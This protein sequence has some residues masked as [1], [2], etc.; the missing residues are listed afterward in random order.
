VTAVIAGPARLRTDTGDAPAI[1][2][3]DQRAPGDHLLIVDASTLAEGGFTTTDADRLAAVV[4]RWTSTGRLAVPDGIR[5]V[6]AARADIDG[7]HGEL[8]LDRL[9]HLGALTSP[10]AAPATLIVDH[11]RIATHPAPTDARPATILAQE[12]LAALAADPGPDAA[13]L[14]RAL[15]RYLARQ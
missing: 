14:R 8:R 2:V 11:K 15:D 1:W 6:V 9:D 4:R 12:L 10:D 5:A 13:A 7:L 3:L